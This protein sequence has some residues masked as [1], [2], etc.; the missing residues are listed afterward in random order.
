MF[1]FNN[2]VHQRCVYNAINRGLRIKKPLPFIYD[3]KK[4]KPM[5]YEIYS[6]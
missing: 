5:I 2:P 3:P 6:H 1:D 4:N